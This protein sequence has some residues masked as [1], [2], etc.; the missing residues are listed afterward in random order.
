MAHVLVEIGPSMS[1]PAARIDRRV[2]GLEGVH[3]EIGNRFREAEDSPY[4]NSPDG[5][6]TVSETVSAN[7]TART[8][9]YSLSFTR[10]T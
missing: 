10:R 7:Q 1:D 4:F 6:T 8:I 3:R 2:G 5:N 9:R